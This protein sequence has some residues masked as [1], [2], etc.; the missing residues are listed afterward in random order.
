MLT[1]KNPK[2]DQ[3]CNFLYTEFENQEA[4]HA[5]RKRK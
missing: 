1:V 5:S 2:F 4:N 3:A